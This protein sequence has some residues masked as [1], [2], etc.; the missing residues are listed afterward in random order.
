MAIRFPMGVGSVQEPMAPLAGE[1]LSE[2][3]LRGFAVVDYTP[4]YIR[5]A[6]PSTADAVPLPYRGGFFVD[7]PQK[8]AGGSFEP[9]AVLLG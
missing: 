7:E 2:A 9:P 1:L 6:N 8:I 3:K 5:S 4:C